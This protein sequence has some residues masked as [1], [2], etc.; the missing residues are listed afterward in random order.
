MGLAIAATVLTLGADAPILGAVA[1]YEFAGISTT[2]A[3]T[4]SV[5]GLDAAVTV[6][7]CGITRVGCAGAISANVMDI[8]GVAAATGGTIRIMSKGVPALMEQGPMGIRIAMSAEERVARYS[9]GVFGLSLIAGAGADYCGGFS[10][11][12]G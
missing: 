3:L 2:A 4:S 10:S 11:C 12:S 7:S 5:I 9:G 8:V 1:A 6:N